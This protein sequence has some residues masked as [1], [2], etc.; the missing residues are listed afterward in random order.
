ML[1]TEKEKAFVIG[2]ATGDALGVPVEFATRGQL[3]KQPIEEMIGYGNHWQVP[4]TWSDDTSLTI[5]TIDSLVHGYNP[6][7]IAKNFVEWFDDGKYSANGYVFDIGSTTRFA[8][9]R[10]ELLGH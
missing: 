1:K 9:L 6:E 3:Q 2:F 5:A 7:D 10:G 4:G 8:I